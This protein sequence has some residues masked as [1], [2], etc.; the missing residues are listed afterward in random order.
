MS[1]PTTQL[2]KSYSKI[3]NHTQSS[4]ITKLLEKNKSL[5]QLRGCKVE[6][7]CTEKVHGSNFSFIVHKPTQDHETTVEV[8]NRN[9]ILDVFSSFFKDAQDEVIPRYRLS[10]IH[11]FNVVQERIG[12]LIKQVDNQP[13]VVT[14]V[15]I[16]GELFGGYFPVMGDS[17]LRKA[18]IQ[19]GVYYCPHYDFYVFDV[20]VTVDNVDTWLHFDKVDPLLEEAGFRLRTKPLFRGSLQDCLN[21]DTEFNTTIPETFYSEIMKETGVTFKEKENICEGIVIKPADTSVWVGARAI[22]KKKNAKFTEVNPPKDKS[23]RQ[24]KAQQTNNWTD[25]KGADA[26]NEIER[27]ITEN[28]LMNVES[29]VGQISKHNLPLVMKEF[30]NDIIDDYNKDCEQYETLPLHVLNPEDQK[31]IKKKLANKSQEIV[32]NYLQK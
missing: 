2:F 28:R 22:I 15:Q 25:M 30:V 29:K 11:L 26:W 21:F 17:T 20:S 31:K 8:A 13:L 9:K 16:F 19:K 23:N 18:H 7:I 12:T 14:K 4:F 24:K 6:W 27:Y 32:K 1:E 3:E 5:E 10:S